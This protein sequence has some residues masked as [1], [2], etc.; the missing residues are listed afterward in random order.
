MTAPIDPGHHAIS[1]F[2]PRDAGS[3]TIDHPGDFG[4]R[5]ERQ[6][7]FPLILSLGHQARR[8]RHA[9]VMDRDAHFSRTWFRVRN[10]F[11][12][13]LPVWHP[14]IDANRQHPA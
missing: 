4:A 2:E 14:L 7:W 8:E 10:I 1:R 6:G 11:N 12:L 13:K 3:D 9:S 5:R